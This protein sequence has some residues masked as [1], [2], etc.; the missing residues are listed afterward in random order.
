MSNQFTINT[1]GDKHTSDPIQLADGER[2]ADSGPEPEPRVQG[3]SELGVVAVDQVNLLVGDAVK[4]QNPGVLVQ[5]DADAPG[6]RGAEEFLLAVVPEGEA[7]S[8]PVHGPG[9][10]VVAQTAFI[11]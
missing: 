4:G 9:R 7:G 1:F 5:V 3:A 11:I 10:R 6:L 8:G 2:G